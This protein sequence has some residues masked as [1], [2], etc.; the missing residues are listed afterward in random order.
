MISERGIEVNLKKIQAIMETSP[1]RTIKDIQRLA[2]RVV[3]LSIF[4][5][6][7]ADKCLP[8]FKALR[9]SFSWIEECQETFEELAL[10]LTSPPLLKS[11]RIVTTLLVKSEGV[12]QFPVYYII[13]VLQNGELRYSKIEKCIYALIVA[14]HK[15]RPYFQA[16]PIVMVTNQPMKEVLSKTDTSRR[17]TKWSI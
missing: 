10:Y 4:I 7:M 8:F 15:L 13:K 16:H 9:T 5:S 17:M 12:H 1:L 14:A 6:R 3:A 11:P 2:R